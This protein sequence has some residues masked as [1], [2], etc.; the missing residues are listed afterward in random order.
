MGT[1]VTQ[2]PDVPVIFIRYE[3]FMV[4]EY[5][6]FLYIPDLAEILYA[7]HCSEFKYELHQSSR[8]ICMQK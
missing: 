5:T 7:F 4:T 1:A 3:N 2:A 6:A 8:N